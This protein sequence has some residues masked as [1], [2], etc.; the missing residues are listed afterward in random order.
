MSIKKQILAYLIDRHGN[1][2]ETLTII[3][4]NPKADVG[5]MNATAKAA[6]DGKVWWTLTAPTAQP[7]P[8]QVALL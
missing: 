5:A 1:V 3:A 6:T 2:Y 7:A 8:R 4:R